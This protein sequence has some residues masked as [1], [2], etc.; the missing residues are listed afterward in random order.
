MNQILNDPKPKQEEE[1][2]DVIDPFDN[3]DEFFLD[4]N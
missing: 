4:E 1:D 2:D 3:L